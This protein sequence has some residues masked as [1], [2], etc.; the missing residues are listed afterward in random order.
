[1]SNYQ[2]GSKDLQEQDL[3]RQF[4]YSFAETRNFGGSYNL[5]CQSGMIFC[6]YIFAVIAA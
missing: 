3:A 4:P 2:Y 6:G 1:M 5:I